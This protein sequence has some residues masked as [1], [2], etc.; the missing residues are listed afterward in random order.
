MEESNNKEEKPEFLGK[1]RELPEIK[2]DSIS[3]YDDEKSEKILINDLTSKNPNN[4]L[5]K[6]CEKNKI[7]LNF[8]NT[9]DIIE[10]LN[11][12]KIK[13]PENLEIDINN[14]ITFN[15]KKVMCQE[16]LK[17]IINDGNKYNEFFNQSIE[18]INDESE[19]E[20]EINIYEE[21]PILINEVESSKN[22]NDQKNKETENIALSNSEKESK[23]N[24]NY[25]EEEQN[26][27]QNQLNN[28]EVNDNKV[29]NNEINNNIINNEINN[30]EINN[31]EINNNE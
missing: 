27:E 5:C 6:I 23:N 14:N 29:N 16:C 19:D 4:N 31:N 25:K 30:N 7:I 28:N 11:K 18:I 1:K 3:E 20:A 24:Q 17:K 2:L 12:E 9:N 26:I 8:E 13:I 10:Y 15:T 21:Q 22:E